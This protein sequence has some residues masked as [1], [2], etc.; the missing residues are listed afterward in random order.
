MDSLLNFS[1]TL[2]TIFF[3]L[4]ALVQPR[5]FSKGLSI[6]PYKAMGITEIRTT[7]GGLILGL[8]FYTAIYQK[9]IL[10]DCLGC[11]WLGAA[12]VRIVSMFLIDNSY[13]KKNL[14]FALIEIIVGILLLI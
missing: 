2:I 4:W 13:S 1:G 7:Y 11:A 12:S 5:K 6:T 8:S 10:Y 14:I 9:E 3:G